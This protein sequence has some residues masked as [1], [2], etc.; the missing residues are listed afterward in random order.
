[1]LREIVHRHVARGDTVD[2]ICGSADDCREAWARE[3]P[4]R[5]RIS[6]FRAPVDRNGPLSAR[7]LNSARLLVSGLAAILWP[8]RIDLLYLFTYPPVLPG[9]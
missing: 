4:E 2:V 8:G 6:S 1:M 3:F 7:V 5:V 9:R